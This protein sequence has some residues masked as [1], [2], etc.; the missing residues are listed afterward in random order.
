MDETPFL[1][2]F[3]LGNDFMPGCL[4]AD[5][6]SRV[7]SCGPELMCA[8]I[9]SKKSVCITPVVTR[10]E[11]GSE[12]PEVGAGGG[13]RDLCQ[14]HELELSDKLAIEQLE[15]LCRD[16]ITDI[17]VLSRTKA[18]LASAFKSKN[19]VLL[20]DQYGVKE[21]REM[22]LKKLVTLLGQGPISG[23]TPCGDSLA[24]ESFASSASG[25][26]SDNVLG[27]SIVSGRTHKMYRALANRDKVN[28]MLYIS[29][30]RT[31]ATR[32]IRS[33]VNLSRRLD[34]RTST[35]AQ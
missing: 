25:G 12:V 5:E 2:G 24:S 19:K 14:S 35:R 9:E 10:T 34:L 29:V 30:S 26:N 27:D 21:D 28:W 15:V 31:L 4:T 16:Q 6:S 1:S 11:D 32:R 22:P 33:F 3:K 20:L 13:V 17:Q 23:T 7:H 8:S 18:V